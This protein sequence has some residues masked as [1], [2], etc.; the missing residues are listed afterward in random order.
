MSIRGLTLHRQTAVAQSPAAELE[1]Q[2]SHSTPIRAAQQVEQRLPLEQPAQYQSDNF[3]GADLN[4]CTVSGCYARFD[5]TATFLKHLHESHL[6]SP[7]GPALPSA[8]AAS[9]IADNSML[10]INQSS[11]AGATGIDASLSL[12]GVNAVE[13]TRM[14]TTPAEA[15]HD[16]MDTRST[17]PST[18]SHMWPSSHGCDPLHSPPSLELVHPRLGNEYMV[19]AR[20]FKVRANKLTSGGGVLGMRVLTSLEPKVGLPKVQRDNAALV[21]PT[22][23]PVEVAVN[24]GRMT[25]T[26]CAIPVSTPALGYVRTM[27]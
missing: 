21:T 11:T 5:S 22:I 26:S 27:A 16:N 23:D 4:A 7:N 15:T 20:F 9:S 19:R 12:L 6:T 18:L 25:R 24:N 17:D 10:R 8:T 2:D 1:P 13:Q 14:R 3:A